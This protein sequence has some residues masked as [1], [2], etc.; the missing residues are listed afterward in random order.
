MIKRLLTAAV[1]I[2]LAVLICACAS[3]EMMEPMKLQ[4]AAS[5][6]DTQ[7]APVPTTAPDVQVAPVPTT[8][9]EQAP[10]AAESPNETETAEESPASM[11]IVVRDG[12]TLGRDIIPQIVSAT[13]MPA[14]YIE[15]AFSQ[16]QSELISADASGFA[17]MEGIIPPGS[18]DTSGMTLGQCVDMWV[19]EAEKRYQRVNG[20]VW[21]QNSLTASERIVLASIVEAETVLADKYESDVAAALLNRLN[22][23]DYLCS[24]AT[25]EYALGFERPSLNAQ[26][27]EAA[28]PYNTYSVTGLPPGAI[29][30]M[31]DQSLKAACK[32]ARNRKTYY[33]YYDYI[34]RKIKMFSDYDEYM[35]ASEGF[36][37]RFD[38]EY[39]IRRY[40]VVDKRAFFGD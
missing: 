10:L 37:N 34:N 21:N 33:Y 4:S 11:I 26:D 35:A 40:A 27:I 30:C 7:A 39:D 14:R 5:T 2:I 9:P 13:D 3:A 24:D 36:F 6:A 38:E 1:F 15:D 18:Y 16:A 23:N 28:S 17:R 12:D 31:D 25:V 20:K 19:A 32:K 29:C 22:A 8:A